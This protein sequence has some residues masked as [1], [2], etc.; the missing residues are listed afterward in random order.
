M[1]ILYISQVVS[2]QECV[3]LYDSDETNQLNSQRMAADTLFLVVSHTWNHLVYNCILLKPH[4]SVGNRFNPK[5]RHQMANAKQLVFDSTGL[6]C[7]FWVTGDT[8]KTPSL[9]SWQSAVWPQPPPSEPLGHRDLKRTPARQVTFYTFGRWKKVLFQKQ[10]HHLKLDFW[11]KDSWKHLK[12]N[13]DCSIWWHAA[14]TTSNDSHLKEEGRF[15]HPSMFMDLVGVLSEDI[16][17][18]KG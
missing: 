17:P 12:T 18:K 6:F 10:L 16:N 9:P 2:I 14:V 3:L 15:F 8:E 13:S 1:N 7:F 5:K 4:I 11:N